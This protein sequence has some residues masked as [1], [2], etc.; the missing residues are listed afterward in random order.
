MAIRW[1]SKILL[2]KM[3]T[4]YG[5]DPTP[6]GANGILATN[7]VIR[8]MEGQDVSRDLELPYLGAQ[9]LMPVGLH[10]VLTCR[11]ELVPS[12]T[13]GAAP[14]WG[15]LLR[16]CGCGQTIVADTSVTYNPITDAHESGHIYFW[17]GGTRHRI[18]GVR[19]DATIRANAQGIPYLEFTMTGLYAGV[20][21]VTR[22]AP[23]LTGFNRPRVVTNANTPDFSIDGVDLVMRNF[24][25]ALR[26]Q[27]QTRLLVGLEAI[28]I[29]D[30][31]E[32]ISTQVEAVPLT[33]FDPYDLAD[34][35]EGAELVE[36]E[37]VHGTAAGYVS[38]LVAPTCQVQRPT[39]YANEQ[40]VAEWPLVLNP[41]PATGNDQWSLVLT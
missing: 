39:G 11:V 12:G 15:P 21:E 31:T 29:V 16:C 41:L 2:F 25:L 10:V 6:A 40:L 7:I 27:V 28:V 14:A 26:N 20:S 36:V 1:R 13:A 32:Q 23:T 17:M 5:T 8:P 4:A 33:T 38:T 19:G 34:A 35:E 18:A 9:E 22:V 24:A 37:L 3:E 30:R